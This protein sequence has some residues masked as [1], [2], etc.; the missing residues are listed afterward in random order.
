MV[1]SDGGIF[2]KELPDIM[3]VGNSGTGIITIQSGGQFIYKDASQIFISAATTAEG[4]II[5]TGNGSTLTSS[6]LI[7]VGWN[8]PG[9]IEVS[10]GGKLSA[11]TMSLGRK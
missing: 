10:N 3:R 5:V 7:Y 8:G 11:G 2:T 1:I 4:T 6:T 9:V